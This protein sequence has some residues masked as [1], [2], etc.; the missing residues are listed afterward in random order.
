MFNRVCTL[1]SPVGR[2]R[3]FQLAVWLVL[4]CGFPTSSRAQAPPQDKGSPLEGVERIWH[5]GNRTE[6]VWMAEDE[7]AIFF[8]DLETRRPRAV[9]QIK[10]WLEEAFPGV[11]IEYSNAVAAFC[12]LQMKASPDALAVQGTRLKQRPEVKHTSPVFYPAAPAPNTRMALT[13]Q[14]IVRFRNPLSSASL[15]QFITRFQLS[16]VQKFEASPKSILL[17]RTS[18]SG[19]D[20]L[21]V[22][23][24]LSA[25]PEVEYAY[26]N[27]LRTNP[28]LGPG[29]REFSEGAVPAT[30]GAEATPRKTAPR[31]G[32]A[33][34]EEQSFAQRPVQG[35][36]GASPQP[37]RPQPPR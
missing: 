31:P 9:Q 17:Q 2:P 1:R 16:L 29:S 4:L 5:N 3:V 11:K 30:K 23:N 26:P 25:L 10:P 13:G 35:S 12:R 14:I 6:R 27:W 24:E 22:A 18:V 21:T 36:E 7:I 8:E 19:P 15:S 34:Q 33:K 20:D 32:S 37:G 28:N